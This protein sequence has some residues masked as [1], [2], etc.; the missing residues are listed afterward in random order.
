MKIKKKLILSY[1]AIALFS[2]LLVSI[3]VF[4]SLLS[5]MEKDIKRNSE[6][7][8]HVAKLSIEKF[9]AEPQVIVKSVEPYIHSHTLDL[10]KT[11]QDFQSLIDDNPNLFCLYYADEVP[12]WKGGK[13]F[14]S[15][16]WIPNN[17]YN[18]DERDWYSLAHA[19]PNVIITEPYVDDD[20]HELV[21]TIS[22]AT[23]NSDKKFKGVI[24]IDIN[25]TDLTSIIS[26]IKITNHGSSFLIDKDG[27][28]LTNEDQAKF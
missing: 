6:T 19:S 25:L 21:T 23:Y 17:S 28:Y 11:Q 18:K 24:A 2:V 15:D 27:Y 16:G 5:K 4:T 22:Y 20:T 8:I 13:V 7:Q 14:S 1:A 26:N 9:F 10:E 12:M 3:P